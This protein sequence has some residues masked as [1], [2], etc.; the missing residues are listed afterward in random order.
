MSPNLG[1][2]IALAMVED[3]RRRIGETV[4]AR[5]RQGHLEPVEI[6]APIFIDS[7]GARARA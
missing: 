4:I 7:D 1:R 2:S 3:G 6:T 5:T